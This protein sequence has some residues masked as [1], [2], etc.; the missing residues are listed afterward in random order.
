MSPPVAATPRL[1]PALVP[2]PAVAV[3]PPVPAMAAGPPLTDADRLARTLY[4]EAGVQGVRA[5]EALATLVM[6]RLRAP[7]GAYGATLAAVLSD[8]G[9]FTPAPTAPRAGSSDPAFAIAQRIARRALSGALPDVTGGAVRFHRGSESPAW[10]AG[11]A[12]VAE[13]G[14]LLFYGP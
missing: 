7:G 14:D 6:N 12:P 1:R 8:G 5:M 3:A 4:V 13:V 10:A 9:Q 11:L 2:E